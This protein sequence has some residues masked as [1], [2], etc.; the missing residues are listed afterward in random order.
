MYHSRPGSV[1]PE[2]FPSLVSLILP[3]SF[4]SLECLP[5]LHPSL[6]SYSGSLTTIESLPKFYPF[7]LLPDPRVTEYIH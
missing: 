2:T 7:F 6:S 5:H 4:V 3:E 1:P